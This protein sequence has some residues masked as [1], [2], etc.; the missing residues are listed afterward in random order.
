MPRN[1]PQTSEAIQAE[2]AKLKEMKP[3]V[4]QY[5]VFDDDN[6]EAIEAQIEALEGRWDEDDCY[7]AYGGDGEDDEIDDDR[8]LGM[9]LDAV[10][11]MEDNEKEAP[12]KDW[13][14]LVKG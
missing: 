4:L 3:K 9:T 8:L 11:W 1:M 14:S 12:S 10:H 13:A 5:T 7:D 2:I 6:H